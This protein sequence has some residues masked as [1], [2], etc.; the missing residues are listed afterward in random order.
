MSTID[1]TKSIN[2][3]FNGPNG[4]GSI[5][6]RNQDVR[7]RGVSKEN[8]EKFM[9]T[10]EYAYTEYKDL[11]N[12]DKIKI[13]INYDEALAESLNIKVVRN[14]ME[15]KVDKLKENEDMEEYKG[16][17]IPRS[18]NLTGGEKE[19]YVEYLK[20]IE[21]NIMGDFIGDGGESVMTT[22]LLGTSDQETHYSD[23]EFYVSD[24]PSIND[25]CLAAYEFGKKTSQQFKIA[26]IM[27]NNQIVGFTCTFKTDN[28]AVKNE[29]TYLLIG[30]YGYFIIGLFIVIILLFVFLHIYRKGIKQNEI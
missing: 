15:V 17:E 25:A 19:S 24:Y 8:L 7:I 14:I 12:G 28:I 21:G 22:W 27:E 29:Q 9:S 6:I 13:I 11:S 26:S 30:Q 10:L 18:W 1:L 23:Q 3:S 20:S 5:Q 2:V 4:H 16:Y